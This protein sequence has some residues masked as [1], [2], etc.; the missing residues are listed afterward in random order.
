MVS[1]MDKRRRAFLYYLGCV[2]LIGAGV[3]YLAAS[4]MGPGVSTDSAMILAAGDNLVKGKG[5]VDYSGKELTQFPPLYSV[6]LGA[7]SA[8]FQQDIFVVG[9]FLNVIIFGALIWFGGLYLYDAFNEEPI[10]AYLGSFILLTSTSLLE[11]SANIASDPLFLLIVIFFLMSASAYLRSGDVRYAILVAALAMVSCFQRYAGLSLVIAGSLIVAYANRGHIARAVGYALL[12]A[13]VSGGPI[14]AWG[15]LH[16][17]P[18]NGTIFGARLPSVASGNFV[19][20]AEKMLYWFIPYRV[21]SAVGVVPLF[22]VIAGAFLLAI[23][24]TGA[25]GFVAEIRRPQIVSS[26]ILLAVYLAVLVF[27]ISYYELKG[28]K[29][30]RVH[31]IALPSLLVVLSVIG[32]RLLGSAKH[33]FGTAPVYA[34]ITILFLAWSAYPISKTSEYVR[35]SMAHGDV[36]SYNSINKGSVRDSALAHYLRGLDL[37]GKKVYSN[38]PDTVWLI[39]ETQVLP[40]PTLASSDRAEELRRRFQKWPGA[41]AEGYIVWIHAE[42]YKTYYATPAELSSIADI[43]SL[44]SGENADVYVIKGRCGCQA[45]PGIPKRRVSDPADDAAYALRR[46]PFIPVEAAF[47]L[48]PRLRNDTI[49]PAHVTAYEPPSSRGPGRSPLKA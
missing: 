40:L 49:S 41:Y 16:N 15:F 21:I 33:R 45:R 42:A 10:L 11:I 44:Y 48:T 35:E 1:V 47:G 36:S 46:R 34:A 23:F 5:L 30:D 6:I 27:N 8:I 24:A 32:G 19:A 2:A 29:T 13:L 7:G 43:T 31:I 39:L 37:E 26:L 28:L 22:L 9:W 20:G 17:A 14:F 12:F 25:K 3:A 18:V 38:G 4:K